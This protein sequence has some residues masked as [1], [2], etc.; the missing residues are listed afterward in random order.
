[1]RVVALCA[2]AIV[3]TA[4]AGRVA[5]NGEPIVSVHLLAIND[6]HGAL[7][8]AAGGT[9]R[10]G[11]VDA[12]GVEYLATHLARL[13]AA[14]PHT[15]IVSAGDN[16]GGSPLLS[17]LSH[18]EGAVEALNLAE[19][20][21]SAV[22]N[23]ELDEGWSELYRMQRGGCHPVDGCQDGTPF[24]GAAFSYLAA[25][26]IFDPRGANPEDLTR[27]GV[28]GSEPR[29]LFPPYAIH[30]VAGVRVGF[31]GAILDEAPT[32]IIAAGRRDLSFNPVVES[33]NRAA[34]ALRDEGVR[35]I[36]V[37]V[38]EG[39]N[40]TGSDIN[41][42]DLRTSPSFVDL[43]TRLSDDV[44]VVL[45]G[46]SHVAYNCTIDG[47]LVTSAASFGVVITDVDLRI[48]RS[49]GE[50]VGKNARNVVVTRDVPKTVAESAVIA[51]YRPVADTVGSRLVGAIEGSLTR[52]ASESGESALGEL[53]A[54]AMLDAARRAAG[55]G[56]D[57]AFWNPGGIR[58]DLVAPGGT[59]PTPVTYAQL[60]SVLPFGNELIVKSLKGEAILEALEQQF[61]ERPR[62]MQF[63]D[64]FTYAYDAA[65]PAGQ[66]ID[67]GSVRVGGAPLDP[68]RTYR[69]ATSNFL[70]GTGDG[71]KALAGGTD[72]VLIGIDVDI[73]AEYLSRHSPARPVVHDRIRRTR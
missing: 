54:D 39:A 36:V 4:A 2:A 19:L 69:V 28:R 9:G 30:N 20:Q 53:I 67:R 11:S 72:P 56:V 60:F 66:R 26:I 52:A 34:R 12:G 29:P 65:R 1:M 22:G 14:N 38:H 21:Y 73:T 55:A 62:I 44:D 61:G 8:P 47:K 48:R 57:L 7:E 59:G 37:L 42:C 32:V 27:A 40:Y 68:G 45:S 41:A 58:A 71:L 18:D 23:H 63:A 49:D 6:F 13:K 17:S 5:Q 10:V 43:V 70:W 35:A 25:N 15:V 64:G 33:V 50:V 3:A 24:S 51:N 16:I 31:I 46:H